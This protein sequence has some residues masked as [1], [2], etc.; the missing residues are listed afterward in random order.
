[1]TIDYRIQPKKTYSPQI[2]TLLSM[3][4]HTR[5]VTLSEIKELSQEQLDQ[6]PEP[7][8]NS[9]GALLQ[10]MV[11]IEKAHQLITFEGRDFT[12]EE[13]KDWEA[14]LVLGEKG[15]QF[16]GNTIN[17]YIN[18]LTSMR[19][20]TK[21]QLKTKSDEWLWGEYQWPHGVSYNYHFMWYHVMEDEI[22]HRGQIRLLK[23]HL[24]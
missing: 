19:E 4:E 14:S 21:R 15:H 9:I 12:A 8:Q 16:Q 18:L 17:H 20:E 13:W 10:H 6:R 22:N 3:L 24:K 5:E 1:M 2:G 11:G 23:K 7:F